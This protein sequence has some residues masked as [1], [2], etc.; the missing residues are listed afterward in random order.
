MIPIVTVP[1]VGVVKAVLKWL[2]RASL[3]FK[4]V[5]FVSLLIVLTLAATAAITIRQTNNLVVAEKQKDADASARNI[6]RV[7]ELPLAVGDHAELAAQ[8]RRFAGEKGICFV[9]VYDKKGRLVSSAPPGVAVY[10]HLPDDGNFLIGDSPVVLMS[11]GENLGPL[12]GLGKDFNS[13]AAAPSKPAAAEPG[14][15]VVGRVVIGMSKDALRQA[16]YNQAATT[17][18]MVVIAALVAGIIILVVV[19]LWTRRLNNLVAASDL[20][21]QGDYSVAVQSTS[22]DEIG[23]LAEA[24]ENM[25][26]A[27]GHRDREMRDF[28]AGLQ[29]KV[30]ERTVEL[31]LAKDVAEAASKAKSEFLAKMSHEIRTPMNGV[32]GMID[33]LRGTRLDD[34]QSRYANIAKTSATALLGLINDI[35]DFSKIEAGKMEL[36]IEEM[37]LWKTVEDAV[38]L[39]SSKAVEKGLE[40]MCNIHGDVPAMVRGDANRLR[41]ILINLLGNALKFTEKGNVSVEVTTEPCDSDHVKVRCQV[42]DTGVGIP[43]DRMD[44]LFRLFTQVDSSSTRRYGGTG[45][46]LAIA[47][48][49]S[50]IMGGDVGVHSEAGKGSTFWF[51][52][53]LGASDQP[54]QAEARQR[55]GPAGQTLRVLVVDDNAVNLDILHAQI[56]SWGFDV[57]TAGGGEEA[58]E[59]LYE[60]TGEG[61]TF[62]LG[63]LDMNMPGMSGTDLARAIKASGKLRDTTLILL[64]SLSCSMADAKGEFVAMLTKPVRQSQLLD[65][66]VSA[67]PSVAVLRSPS[68]RRS[69]GS[70]HEISNK[71]RNT[72]ARVLLAEDNEIN[73]EVAHEILLAA[74]VECE[75]VENGKLALEAVARQQYDLVLMDC[76]MPE[77]DGFATTKKIRRLEEGGAVMCRHAARL[78]IIAMT[79]NAIKG[80]RESCLEAGMDDYMSKPIEPDQLVAMLNK[81]LPNE[82]PEPKALSPVS[83]GDDDRASDPVR[84]ASAATTMAQPVSWQCATDGPFDFASLLVRC[85]GKQDFA[86][87][88]LHAFK[89]KVLGDLDALEGHVLA[90]D[91]QKIAFVA[92]GLKG[93]AANVSAKGLHQAAAE[94]EQVAKA[95]DFGRVEACLEAVRREIR[96]CVDYLSKVSI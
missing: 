45:L 51:T 76:Q 17:V 82:S 2:D 91:A 80:D 95:A 83:A 30:D 58:L 63:I 41:Q 1:T 69:D 13:Q 39:M 67:F 18:V 57:Q 8:T 27:I 3:R 52:A 43:P 71:V 65:A 72:G 15:E 44:R 37:D 14:G 47:K 12:G 38:E 21:S 33:L 87:R 68:A 31:L 73:Q 10:S 79:A 34:K 66:V 81:H 22:E 74:G 70:S 48:R 49:L 55:I 54:V 36:D 16:Q 75:I 25:R 40:L 53:C 9:A 32:I 92:H 88:I 90:A 29:Q 85:M 86:E 50:E 93:S 62:D 56:A 59:M 46:G 20:M 61:R 6:A 78:P 26:S 77:M 89:G 11:G 64:T 35:L 24:F 84:A 23:R 4:A 5:A 28:N 96:S 42:R 94:L 60:A 7:C 19:S